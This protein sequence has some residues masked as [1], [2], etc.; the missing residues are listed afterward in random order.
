ML[1]GT[2]MVHHSVQLYS[3]LLELGVV[4]DTN[5]YTQLWSTELNLSAVM[6]FLHAEFEVEL[7]LM[8]ETHYC[9]MNSLSHLEKLN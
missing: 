8:W 1:C 9:E 7:S 3:T 5:Y 6:I 2:C 4:T